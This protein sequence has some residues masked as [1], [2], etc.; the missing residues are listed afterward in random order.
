MI[1]GSKKEYVSKLAKD[2][3]Q[4]VATELINKAYTNTS[5]LEAKGIQD[6][7]GFTVVNVK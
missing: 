6:I 2:I 4:G 3:I 1:V 7:K 5:K